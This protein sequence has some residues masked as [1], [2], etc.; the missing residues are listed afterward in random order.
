MKTIDGVY[1]NGHVIPS[2]PVNW[3]EGMRVRIQPSNEESIPDGLS[4]DQW[5]KTAEQK[6]AWAAA[7]D[8]LE[9]ME[10]TPEEEAEWTK[11]RQD[12]KEYTLAKM[13]QQAQDQS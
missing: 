8:A 9:P 3:P 1:R 7:I 13:R 6:A 2:V 12:V 10:L 5:P 4:E 11:A